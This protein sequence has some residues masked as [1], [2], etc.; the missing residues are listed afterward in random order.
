VKIIRRGNKRRT[1]SCG[2]KFRRRCVRYRNDGQRALLSFELGYID[3]L[4][5]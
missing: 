4:I 5:A 3:Y 2:K 1:C